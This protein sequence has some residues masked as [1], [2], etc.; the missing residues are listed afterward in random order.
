[1]IVTGT[2]ALLAQALVVTALTLACIWTINA[3]TRTPVHEHADMRLVTKNARR[4]VKL[5]D[6][7]LPFNTV[8]NGVMKT[9]HNPGGDDYIALPDS[10]NEKGAEMTYTFWMSLESGSS[11]GNT[12]S[13]T[14]VE[15]TILLRGINRAYGVNKWVKQN[16][17]SWV[18][19]G[20][21]I[22]DRVVKC[23][24]V[25]VR[26]TFISNNNYNIQLVVQWNSTG[27]MMKEE[28]V[29]VDN[30]RWFGQWNH[31]AVVFSPSV[32]DEDSDGGGAPVG[33]KLTVYINER[34]EFTRT[35]TG[36]SL[37]TNDGAL[38]VLPTDGDGT[39]QSM[40]GTV[41]D[42]RYFNYAINADH[43]VKLVNSKINYQS[44]ATSTSDELELPENRT[45]FSAVGNWI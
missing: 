40:I 15:R 39:S 29:S 10:F 7:K 13:N 36:E 42:V 44:A 43:V 24:L 35:Y 11:D 17:S 26:Q 38:Y 3:F 6:G 37:R 18:K 5:V 9:T 41:A 14:Q 34:P 32:D 8:G 27:D 4:E 21:T 30:L 25:K 19:S 28:V 33:S 45:T 23:P 20:S 1:M 22:T 16:G 2:I 31:I 12:A